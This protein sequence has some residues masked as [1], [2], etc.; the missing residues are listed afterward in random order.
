MTLADG[1]G[2]AEVF[3]GFVGIVGVVSGVVLTNYSQHLFD[4]RITDRERRRQLR[5]VYAE[6]GAAVYEYLAAGEQATVWS[7]YVRDQQLMSEDFRAMAVKESTDAAGLAMKAETRVSIARQRIVLLDQ[8]P[9]R[10][11]AMESH[12]KT[13]VA[14]Q[15]EFMALRD[16]GQPKRFWDIAG[17]P[18]E[19]LD[20]WL[21]D[22]G[23][24]I[25]V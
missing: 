18:R 24:D 7:T 5:E 13:F 17:K 20:A 16:Q 23:R 12:W 1:L 25:G 21:R 22:V 10:I 9:K 11:D 15:R 6:F 14:L 19:A 3:S 8:D 2:L 4:Q